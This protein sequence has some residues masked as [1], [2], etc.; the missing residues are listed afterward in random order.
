MY[1]VILRKMKDKEMVKT[2]LDKNINKIST[3]FLREYKK[4]RHSIF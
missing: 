2:I 4:I 3:N 1:L